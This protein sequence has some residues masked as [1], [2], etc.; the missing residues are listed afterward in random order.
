MEKKNKK[1]NMEDDGVPIGRFTTTIENFGPPGTVITIGHARSDRYCETIDWDS[2]TKPGN[3]IPTCGKPAL[4]VVEPDHIYY[5]TRH[6][7]VALS[8]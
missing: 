3:T 4:Y 6:I 5:C 2:F 1:R 8:L 7:K